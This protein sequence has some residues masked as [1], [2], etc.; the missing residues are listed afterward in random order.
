[1]GTSTSFT[2]VDWSKLP[3]PENDGAARHLLGAPI[4]DV[5]LPSTAGGDVSLAKLPGRSVL[6]IYPMTGTPGMALPDGWDAIPGARG[7]TPHTCAFRDLHAELKSAGA[8][9]VFGLSTQTLREQQDTVQRLHLP[10]PL[11]SDAD[12]GLARAMTLPT[13]VVAGKT[14]IKRLAMIVDDGIVAHVL[15]PVFPP[16]RNAADVLAWLEAHPR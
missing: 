10:F 9:A 11:L 13:M 2:E 16:D 3:V 14:M 12:L 1:M 5:A 4:A 15:Y 8:S 7:C 6:F